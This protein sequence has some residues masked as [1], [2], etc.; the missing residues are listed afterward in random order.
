M[1]KT[2]PVGWRGAIGAAVAIAVGVWL[3]VAVGLVTRPRGD[4]PSGP[5]VYDAS[6]ALTPPTAPAD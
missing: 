2:L 5:P 3:G 1:T 6:G 4:Q